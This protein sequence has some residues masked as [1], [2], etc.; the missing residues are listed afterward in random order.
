MTP[1]STPKKRVMSDKW[2]ADLKKKRDDKIKELKK[3]ITSLIYSDTELEFEV[4]IDE[5]TMLIV[6][7][8]V[9]LTNE[10]IKE[11]VTMYYKKE[12]PSQERLQ[13]ADHYYREL[14]HANTMIIE[15][16]DNTVGLFYQQ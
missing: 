4:L 9:K 16:N 8:Q 3:G 1:N 12:M 10:E 11:F 14:D 13:Q 7:A 2:Y 15:T 6:K 5:S